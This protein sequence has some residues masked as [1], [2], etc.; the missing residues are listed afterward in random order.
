MISL[1]CLF[2]LNCPSLGGNLQELWWLQEFVIGSLRS[3]CVTMANVVSP[4]DSHRKRCEMHPCQHIRLASHCT[5]SSTDLVLWMRI[6]KCF[7]LEYSTKARDPGVIL[8]LPCPQMT[9]KFCS[10]HLKYFSRYNSFCRLLLSLPFQFLPTYPLLAGH[11]PSISNL[12]AATL[13]QALLIKTKYDYIIHRLPHLCIFEHLRNVM[14]SKLLSQS[15]LISRRKG[16]WVS[17]SLSTSMK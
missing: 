16:I 17:V 12:V 4:E 15:P 6:H 13:T 9:I 5:V 3:I 1:S 11:L 2:L 8:P 7:K 10:F 14:I